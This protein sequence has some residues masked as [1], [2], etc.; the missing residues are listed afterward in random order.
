MIQNAV[1]LKSLALLGGAALAG[2]AAGAVV[3]AVVLRRLDRIART[4]RSRLDDLVVAAV[5][6][7]VVLWGAVV[8]LY[9]G[10]DLA[11]LPPPVER[12]AQ[13]A[14]IV[15]VVL[16]VTW[17][18][19]GLT[20]A[21]VQNLAA[22]GGGPLPSATLITNLARLAV[23][24]VGVLVILQTLGISITP[25]ITALGVGGLAVALALQDTLA[26]LFAGVHILA[27][28][29]IRP[30]DFVRLES[31]EEG[32]VQDVTWRN[33][34]IR[35]LP[36]DLV[37]VPNAK[38]AGAVITNYHL[39]DQEEGVRIGVGV[40]YASD[41]AVVEQ[42]TLEVARE[43]Q[44]DVDIAVSDFE[45]F[46]RYTGF[47]DSSINFN[48]ILRAREVV[49]QHVL[50]HEFIKRLHARYGREGIEIPFPQ[51]T[52]HWSTGSPP[53]EAGGA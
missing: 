43:V 13:R 1:W 6:G 44:R 36:N 11:Q 30:G 24:A 10:I 4:T 41:L 14:L 21:W 31:G 45:P 19:A 49:G 38:L 8:G 40:S 7:P 53:N 2:L 22:A 39:P 35:R 46:M 51:R 18:V 26:N 25:I 47:G 27:T 34:T 15:L 12:V 23:L 3:R 17:A 42:V 50:R 20:G 52:I 33:T 37:V 48:V 5:R 29:Q 32:Y 28:R 16:S 9:V